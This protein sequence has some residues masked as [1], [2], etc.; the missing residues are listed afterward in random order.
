MKK[1]LALLIFLA[2]LFTGPLLYLSD[3]KSISWKEASREGAGIVIPTQEAEILVLGGRTFGWKGA[4]AIHTWIAYKTK[5]SSSYTVVEKLGWRIYKG[6]NG[7]VFKE[8]LP[9]RYWYGSKPE[10]LLSI[11]GKKAEEL[12]PKIIEAANEYPYATTYHYWPGPNSNTFIA[13]IARQVPELGLTMPTLAIGK[14]YLPYDEFIAKTSDGSGYQISLYGILGIL[15][16]KE[17]GVQ[18]NLCGLVFGFDFKHAA[19]FLPGF[20]KIALN[21]KS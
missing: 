9:D 13:F 11:H 14:D 18:V 19:I 8:D 7:V 20:G 15:I 5:E 3:Y 4:F 21:E 6:L 2:L 12:I 10:L 16:S 17:E 1:I